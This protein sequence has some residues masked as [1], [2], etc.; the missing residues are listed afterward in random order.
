MFFIY[1]RFTYTS[2][3]ITTLLGLSFRFA[4]LSLLSLYK[5]EHNAFTC[6]LLAKPMNKANIQ[7]LVVWQIWET[8][9][10]DSHLDSGN[11]RETDSR[12]KL[13]TSG[14]R[15]YSENLIFLIACLGP[16]LSWK[17]TLDWEHW[18][19]NVSCYAFKI[20]QK[21]RDHFTTCLMKYLMH[22]VYTGYQRCWE[23]LGLGSSDKTFCKLM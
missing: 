2:L 23:T 1:E 22:S 13:A 7:Q 19:R 5:R 9:N 14:N 8:C 15:E 11:K 17:L 20:S 16:E 4:S 6:S 10:Q 18:V 21:Q 3:L 12:C